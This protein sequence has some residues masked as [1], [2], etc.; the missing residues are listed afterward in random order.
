MVLIPRFFHNPIDQS[1]NQ[2]TVVNRGN[3]ATK[4]TTMTATQTTSTEAEI[5]TAYAK[6]APAG[7][8]W[9]GL[10]E[11]RTALPMINRAELD[12]GLRRLSLHHDAQLAEIENPRAVAPA[13][14]DAALLVGDRLHQSIMIEG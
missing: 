4:E 13:D 14:M 2:T 5:R 7:R 6:I 9:V 12:R 1:G 8:E 11:I 3:A 10:A